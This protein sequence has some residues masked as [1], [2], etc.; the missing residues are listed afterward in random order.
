LK[1]TDVRATVHRVPTRP[2]LIDKDYPREVVFVRV[3][4]D[5][6]VTGF[7]I[8]SQILRWSVREFINRELGP[9]VKGKNALDTESIWH[10]VYWR[11]NQRGTSGAV[12]MGLSALDIALWDAKG[13]YLNQPVW[14]LL[15]GNSIKVPAY[16]TF[17][18]PDYTPEQLVEVAKS[19]IAE[20]QDKLKMVVAH[21][22][23]V[24]IPDDV[25]RVKA[26]REAIGENI[27]LMIDANQTLDFYSA[28]QLCSRLE[29]YN[30]TWFEEPIYANDVRQ[31]AE[32]RRHTSIP[33][34]AGQ[35][36]G[37]RWRHKDLIVGGA[38]D[39]CQPN[40]V[41]VGGYTEGQRVAH[42][43]QAFSLPIA[44]GGGWPHH[45]AHLH[46][47]VANGWRVE[48]HYVM[49]YAGNAIFKNSPQP[50]RGWVT[51]TEQPGLGMEPN[52]EMLRDT[53]EQ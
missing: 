15:G 16:I 25:P 7:G 10:D 32:L 43:A 46:A 40:V 42:L 39:I 23:S 29:P 41:Y 45:N 5:Q 13:K 12:S 35:N 34:S 53:E 2:P 27:E 24:D 22:G 17:G 31:M 33:I 47:G 48:F 18:L 1:V 14:R 20:G 51:L 26:V 38:V 19:L 52:E 6:G 8:T 9:F 11:F 50:E 36:E 3:E 21:R 49:W 44:N 37:N 28:R 4:T 30:L